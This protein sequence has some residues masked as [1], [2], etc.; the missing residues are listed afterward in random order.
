MILMER[1]LVMNLSNDGTVVA[2]GAGTND[3][4][5]SYSGHVRVYA[6][7]SSSWIQRGADIDGEAAYDYSGRSVSLSSEDGT[8]VAIGANRHVKVYA[9][10]YPSWIQMGANIDGEDEYYF[11]RHSVSL[12]S[13]GMVVAIGAPRNSENGNDSAGHVRVYA[14][15]SSLWI[16]RGADIDGETA[17]DESGRSVSLSNDGTVVAIG[18]LLNDGNGTDSGHVKVYAWDYPSWVQMGNDIDGEDECDRS[19]WSVSLN[20]DGTVVAIGAPYNDENGS[21]SGHVRVYAWDYPSWDQMGADI[22]GEASNDFAGQSV[23]LNSY[24]TVVAIDAHGN[25]DNGTNS[26]HVRVYAWN[27]TS[28]DQMGTDIDGEAASDQ[29]GWSVS[30]SNDGTVVAIGAVGN[31]GNG[32]YSG[33]VRVYSFVQSSDEPSVLPSDEPSV[34]PSDEPSV[35]PSD[36]PSVLPSDEPSVLPSDEP[37]VLPSDEPSVLPSDEPSVLPSDEPSVLPSDEPSV[38]PSDEPSVLP[39]D[40]PSVL[41]SASSLPSALPSISIAPSCIPS[42]SPSPTK[43]P[44]STKDRGLKAK[45]D[46]CSGKSF[47][48]EKSSKSKKSTKRRNVISFGNNEK[49]VK[50][51]KGSSEGGTLVEI[52]VIEEGMN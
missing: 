37:S 41:P 51:K 31:D 5:G 33:H 38:L 14:W 32:S 40:E 39:S 12:S 10:D 3:G 50:D 47:R 49:G 29:S 16:Q 1:L 22:G 20:S 18:A 13:D 2:I 28:W 45:S 43:T 44:K 8:V 17:N 34:L 6:W 46:G 21:Y 24:G 36:E 11:D 42:M 35:L 4:N 26:G 7:N 9:W 19:G 27:S 52:V 15:D 23:S 30:L 48:S 25:D